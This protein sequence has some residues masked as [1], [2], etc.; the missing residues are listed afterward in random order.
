IN[1][2]YRS[3]TDPDIA[4]STV[5]TFLRILTTESD[6]D[7]IEDL[8]SFGSFDGGSGLGAF[9]TWYQ[10]PVNG[11]PNADHYMYFT[12]FDIR[13]AS[14]IAFGSRVC[15]ASGV[16]ITE[17]TFT[18]G[19]GA[20]AAHELGHSLSGA[21]DAQTAG[22][23]D[24]TQNIMST[25]FSLPVQPANTGSPW[26]F[27]SCSIDAFKSY[28]DFFT[29]TEAQNTGTTDRLPA[30]TGDNRAGLVETRD[31]QCRQYFQ[32]SSSSYCTIVQAQNGGES[33]LCGGMYCSIPG[34]PLSCRT[35]LPLEF[36]T[37]GSGK[38]CR[39]GFCVDVEE[40]P[41]TTQPPTTAAPTTTEAPT[42]TTTTTTTEAPTTTTTT[43][44]TEAPTTT[45]TTTTTEAPT[46][47]TT[48]TTTEAPTTTA[49][50]TTTESPTTT[51]TTTTTEVPTTTMTTATTEAPTTMTTTTTSTQSPTTT[52]TTVA[53][54]TT[55][56]PTTTAATQAPTTQQPTTQP[57]TT[58]QAP[59]TSTT[60]LSP[61]NAPTTQPSTTTTTQQPAG[62][63]S[64]YDCIPFLR[65]FDI[66]GF[67]ACYRE[68]WLFHRRSQ[69]SGTIAGGS[70][71]GNSNRGNS[72]KKSTNGNSNG[73]SNKNDKGKPQ[74]NRPHK[75]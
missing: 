33:S 38:W 59:T 53:P 49:T 69:R 32:D 26:K 51:T 12:G 45:T 60:T 52:T 74:S 46:T 7:F 10:D 43:T 8:I 35:M 54:P 29:C 72:N 31:D 30:P 15:T 5:V 23:S 4:M 11:I 47:T 41:T 58:T 70:T 39:A 17:N 57:T 63:T 71:N 48:T 67:W 68:V 34:S 55:E 1:I 36:T 40:D 14:G 21:H 64:I 18:A 2:R 16:S 62:P 61:T 25:I 42:T 65:A 56:V 37:C 50:T 6:D 20:V 13:S 27:S 3:I 19:V 73:I 75:G 66:R 9:R 28:L 44:T 22:C 24:S